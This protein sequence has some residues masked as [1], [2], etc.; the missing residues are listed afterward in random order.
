MPSYSL[1]E[2]FAN[3]CLLAVHNFSPFSRIILLELLLEARTRIQLW[4]QKQISLLIHRLTST[5][6]ASQ[7]NEAT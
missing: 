6:I 4:T 1:Q 7:E 5:R 2:Q 3:N